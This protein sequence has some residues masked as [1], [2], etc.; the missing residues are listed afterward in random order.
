M[1]ERLREGV[2]SI[3]IKIILGLIILSF[4]FTGVSG[5][6]G[7]GNN[8]AAKVDG[9]EISRG[10]FEQAYQ[11][12]RN[13]LQAQYGEQY[14]AL[15]ADPDFVQRLRQSVLDK[16]VNE[17]LLENHARSLGMRISDEQVLNLILQMPE[18]QLDGKFNQ[19]IYETSLR[20]A[21]YTPESFGEV[22]R[23]SEIRNQLLQAVSASEFSLPGEVADQSKLITQ[24]RD[25]RTLELSVEEFAKKAELSDEELQEYYESN[26][27]QFTRPEQVKVSYLE[28]S[29]EALKASVEVTD[30]DVDAYYQENLSQYSSA[31]QRSVSHILVE[32]DDEAKAQAILDDLNAGTDFAELAKTRS[33][34]PGSSD[35][36]GS[37]G[38][39]ERDVMD[40][41]FE[42]AAF[43]LANVGDVTSLVKSDFG[44][45]IIK[46]DELKASETKPL[47][48]VKEEI[49]A[50]LVNQR[51]AESFH[52]IYTDLERVAFESPNSLAPS[53]ELFEGTVQITEFISR[54][55][56]PEILSSPE[57]QE[58]IYSPEVKEDGENSVPVEIAPEH[59][60]VVRV[61]EVREET[62]LP[63]EEVK[64]Q[65]VQQ[66][67]VVKGE[68]KAVELADQLIEALSNGDSSVLEQEGLAFGEQETINRGN[69]LANT[70]FAMT[71]PEEGKKVYSQSKDF[72]GNIVVVE[73]EGVSFEEQPAFAAQIGMQLVRSNGEQDMIALSKALRDKA[74]VEFYVIDNASTHP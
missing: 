70:V 27:A 7:G 48:E 6:I 55:N 26:S 4:V 8:V 62:V 69:P 34:D 65:V 66:L 57:V 13:M 21:G 52:D 1:M 64:E 22:M 36:G 19:D 71:K 17:I 31:E 12:E 41:A 74:D 63:F 72:T 20:R 39:I 50:D 14:A 23:R 43:A 73:L 68:Q 47:S 35:E 11:N 61:D 67:S 10:A 24:T 29:G 18:F 25:I 33:E 46:L 45:H 32:G 28:L 56:A 44:Y 59:V 3:A 58:A 9:I 60:V 37:L 42:E 53:A 16:M 49:K 15:L 40:P 54:F 51:A 38:W 30:E 5:Y 2:N